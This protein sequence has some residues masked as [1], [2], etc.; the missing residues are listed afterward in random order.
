MQRQE[1]DKSSGDFSFCHEEDAARWRS[2][3]VK[4]LKSGQAWRGL[5]L[6]MVRRSDWLGH[7]EG[8]TLGPKALILSGINILSFS[9][10]NL[11]I[12]LIFFQSDQP[13]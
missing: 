5:C 6:K 7:M 3:Q 4:D 1:I 12:F 11:L 10:D 9:G 2:I 13:S 8:S